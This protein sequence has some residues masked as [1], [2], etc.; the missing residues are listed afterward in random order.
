MI[1]KEL[2]ELKS[3]Q[4]DLDDE[5][6]IKL[7]VET[8]NELKNKGYD[9]LKIEIKTSTEQELIKS[10]L[11]IEVFKKIKETQDLPDW[12]VINLMLAS[13]KLKESKF[14][15]RLPNE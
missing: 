7:F 13:G 3:L 9:K 12:V 5:K 15:L 10:D 4:I 6:S 11:D 14:K 1:E 2:I 8:L